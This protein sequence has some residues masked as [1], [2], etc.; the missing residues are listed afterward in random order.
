MGIRGETVTDVAQRLLAHRGWLRGVFRLDV[1]KLTRALELGDANI[2]RLRRCG[3]TV[4][5]A[6]LRHIPQ[7]GFGL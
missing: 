3:Q 2:V 5:S 4:R 6:A 1:A 7:Q